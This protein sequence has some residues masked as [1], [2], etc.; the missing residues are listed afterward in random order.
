MRKREGVALKHERA[1]HL[2]TILFCIMR[3]KE[4]L[5]SGR[6]NTKTDGLMNWDR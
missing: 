2:V 6:C 5:P 4:R 3:D 1:Q